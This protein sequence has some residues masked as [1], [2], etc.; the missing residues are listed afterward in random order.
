MARLIA[1]GN[2]KGGTGKTTIAVNLACALA[3]RGDRVL[4]LDLDPQATAT[5]WAESEHIP[6]EVLAEPPVGAASGGRLQRRLT[7]LSRTFDIVVLDLPPVSSPI[8]AA[9]LLA[10]DLVLVPVTPSALDV[11]PTT[12][13]LE[14]VRSTREARRGTAPKALLVPNRVD[15]R[16]GYDAATRSAVES[17]VERWAPP[18]RL[19]SDHVDAFAA[20]TWVGGYAPE[21]EATQDVLG[22]AY[23]VA[24]ELGMGA[25]PASAAADERLPL[26]A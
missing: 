2:L 22:L 14:L 23:A 8:L 21:S 11:G 7:A 16:A 3:R 4:L 12:A 9:A 20:R 24:R 17:L 25:A 1:S 19:S 15:R 10:V 13:T 5:Q 26:S 6:V 18:V